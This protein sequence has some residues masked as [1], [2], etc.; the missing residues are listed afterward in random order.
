MPDPSSRP[1]A[2]VGAERIVVLSV[3]AIRLG[4]LI[5]MVP[6]ARLALDVSPHRLLAG[7]S[8]VVAA[9]ATLGFVLR[10]VT[11]R[12]PARPWE[13]L[14]DCGLA[15]ALL[16]AGAW[17]VPPDVRVGSWVGFEPGYALSVVVSNVSCPALWALAVGLA[18]V[19][20]GKVTYVW[21]AVGHSSITTVVGDFL[22][23]VVIATIAAATT[24][25]LRRLAAEADVARRLAAADEQRRASL[26]L[27]NGIAMMGLLTEPDLDPTT[28]SV[29]Q[30]Q[31]REEIHRVR[32]Y[33]RGESTPA[34]GR[35]RH[36]VRLAGLLTAAAQEFP[37]LSPRVVADLAGTTEL[38]A[39]D[40][41]VLSAAM[42]SLLLNIRGHAKATATVIHADE[43]YGEW[44]VTVHDDGVGFDPARTELG[45]GLR[46]VVIGEL[47]ARGARVAID[48]MA[49]LGTT[50]TITGRGAR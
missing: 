18:A 3:C 15:G 35:Q 13:T 19:L 14:A 45:V 1:S 32:S 46:Q 22:T 49:G 6:S 48:S 28:R 8:W 50:V 17:T 7:A 40:A 33:L 36:S 37:D 41:E 47:A 12:G 25:F 5:Q 38:D 20:A 2:V 43:Q 39:T 31:A 44:T 34:A 26:V 29:I 23:V 42:T 9:A 27:H 11:R 4:T 30:R 21:S 10:A 24:R 16:V